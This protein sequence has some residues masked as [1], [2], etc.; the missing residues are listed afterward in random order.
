MEATISGYGNG[1]I[2][3]PMA[4]CL[5]EKWARRNVKVEKQ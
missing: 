2:E 3:T 1:L 4:Y 5:P